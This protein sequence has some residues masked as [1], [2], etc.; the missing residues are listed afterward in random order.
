MFI[1]DEI[2]EDKHESQQGHCSEDIILRTMEV[3]EVMSISCPLFMRDIQ[4][5]C[6]IGVSHSRS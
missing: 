1:R 4:G 6:G 5:A 3:T 2:N